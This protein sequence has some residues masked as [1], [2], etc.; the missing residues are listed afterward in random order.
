MKIKRKKIKRR[1]GKRLKKKEEKDLKGF[2]D[3]NSEN[4]HDRAQAL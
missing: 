4:Q 2:E 3:M 1:R